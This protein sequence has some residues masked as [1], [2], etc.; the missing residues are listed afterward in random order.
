MNKEEMQSNLISLIKS[1]N[2]YNEKIPEL[3]QKD[4]LNWIYQQGIDIWKDERLIPVNPLK[5]DLS[6][7]CENKFIEEKLKIYELTNIKIEHKED[8][9]KFFNNLYGFF[10]DEFNRLVSENPVQYLVSFLCNLE[11]NRFISLRLVQWSKNFNDENTFIEIDDRCDEFLKLLVDTLNFYKKSDEL[12]KRTSISKQTNIIY[13]SIENQFSVDKYC[14]ESAINFIYSISK[15]N[16]SSIHKSNNTFRHGKAL[17]IIRA[18]TKLNALKLSFTEGIYKN[19]P[20]L[21]DRNGVFSNLEQNLD[22]NY[23]EY[24]DNLLNSIEFYSFE[25]YANDFTSIAENYFGFKFQHLDNMHKNFNEVIQY[26]NDYYIGLKSDVLDTIQKYAECT[27]E[28]ARKIFDYLLFKVDDKTLFDESS[29][30]KYR[31]CQNCLVE[32][33]GIFFCSYSILVN[34]FLIFKTNILN[35]DV[36]DDL[37]GLLNGTYKKINTEFEHGVAS[38]LRNNL[39][40][41]EIKESIPHNLLNTTL[42]GEIDILMLYKNKIFVIECKNIGKK[43]TLRS[44]SNFVQK[45]KTSSKKAFQ[46]KLKNKVDFIIKNKEEIVSS[47]FN[48][49]FTNYDEVIGL[50]AISAYNSIIPEDDNFFPAIVWT[51]LSE[52]IADKYI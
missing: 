52:W 21:I 23:T 11:Y 6:R 46:T 32:I 19:D 1:I 43:I 35:G 7:N 10:Y 31:I 30:K 38:E 36:D 2:E 37:I 12:L 16:N 34:S 49:D 8:K 33:Q 25:K 44:T 14:I 42:P 26:A 48:G 13:S 51:Q 50:F 15:K 18:I 45:F 47:I 27:D 20:I 9:Y 41:A 4:I 29:Y 40:S 28:E 17:Q 5:N 22:K 24:F 3:Y 39:V